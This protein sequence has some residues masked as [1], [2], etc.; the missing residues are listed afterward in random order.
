MSMFLAGFAIGA[1]PFIGGLAVWLL[2]MPTDGRPA[3]DDV[4]RFRDSGLL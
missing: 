4:T 1:A 2:T 3:D